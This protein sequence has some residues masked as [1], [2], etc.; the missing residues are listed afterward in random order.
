MLSL[1]L[2]AAALAS[3]LTASHA[4]LRASASL[5]AFAPGWLL[6]VGSALLLYAAVFMAYSLVLKYFALSV[7]YPAYTSLSILGVFVV[8]V[9]HF[10]EQITAAKLAGLIAIIAGV[11]LMAS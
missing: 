10:G 7:L 1:L 11:G 9:L 6:R 5:P 4:L 8:G 2:V 3:T